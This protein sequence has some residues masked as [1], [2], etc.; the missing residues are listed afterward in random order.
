MGATGAGKSTVAA[1][2]A[3]QLDWAMLEGDDLHDACSLASLRAGVPLT[4][5]QR[6]PWLAR[7]ADWIDA[8]LCVGSCGVVACSALGRHHRNVLRRPEVTFVH[9]E[10]SRQLLEDRLAR[11]SGHFAAPSLL[12]SQ[13]AALQPPGADEEAVAGDVAGSLT[14]QVAAVIVG[15]GL[16]KDEASPLP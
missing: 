10:G 15:T 5:D 3:A 13:L 1:A 11:R 8:R 2:L 4:D 16:R 9:L 6:L 12:E 14:D 7:V